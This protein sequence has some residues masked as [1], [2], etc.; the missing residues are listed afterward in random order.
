MQFKD[1][2]SMHYKNHIWEGIPKDDEFHWHCV[3]L[4]CHQI[5]DIASMFDVIQCE[6]AIM[7]IS[8]E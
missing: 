6:E 4:K 1:I 2:L 3:C 8:L 5:V 7:N